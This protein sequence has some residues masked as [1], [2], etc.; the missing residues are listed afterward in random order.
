MI[1]TKSYAPTENLHEYTYLENSILYR[2]ASHLLGASFDIE[3]ARGVKKV[4]FYESAPFL[5]FFPKKITPC[6][7]TS[8]DKENEPKMSEIGQ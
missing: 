4:N 6:F 5:N 1:F 7:L 8:K 3:G 2:I